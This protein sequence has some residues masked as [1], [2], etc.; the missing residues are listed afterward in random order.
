VRTKRRRKEEAGRRKKGKKEIV[1]I[2]SEYI[3]II[4]LIVD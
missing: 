2:Y 1:R 4:S 3:L